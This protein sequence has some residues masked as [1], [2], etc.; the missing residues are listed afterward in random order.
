[1]KRLASFCGC[2]NNIDV[3]G[4]VSG[5]RRW[6]CIETGKRIDFA[7]VTPDLMK[8]VY[9]QC[10]QLLNTGYKFWFDKE[11]I[12]DLHKNNAQ[13]METSAEQELLYKFFAPGTIG[14]S[15]SR[16]MT[17]TEIMSAIMADYKAS[18]ISMKKLG[19]L[20][21][22]GGFPRAVKKGVYGYWVNDIEFS[23][24]ASLPLDDPFSDDKIPI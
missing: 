17:T 15:A 22:H 18:K 7:K 6:L 1:M 2:A 8:L 10:L 20:L 14:S 21:R 11:E 3:L 4:D 24:A 19:H 9:S 12:T 23:H 16:W 5:T 13:F